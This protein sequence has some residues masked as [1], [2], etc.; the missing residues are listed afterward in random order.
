MNYEGAK[1]R[2][3]GILTKTFFNEELIHE[4]VKEMKSEE[5]RIMNKNSGFTGFILF[6]IYLYLCKF[7]S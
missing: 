3:K 7:L 6:H 1:V 5:L 2:K 4:E